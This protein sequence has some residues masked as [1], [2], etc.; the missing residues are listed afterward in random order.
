VYADVGDEQSIERDLSTFSAHIANV[1]AIVD[2]HIG[3]ALVLLDEP[4]VG[5]DPEEGAALG[6]GIIRTLDALGAR[7]VVT[8][9]YAAIKVFALS[10][11]SC[12]TAAVGYDLETMTPRYRLTYHSVGESLALPIARRLGLPERILDA[13]EAAR[14]EHARAL[15][16]AMERL[17]ETRRRYEERAAQAE[18]HVR[19]SREMEEETKRLLEELRQKRRRRW[20]EELEEARAFVRNLRER[21]GALLA[22]IER[23]AVDRRDL[24]RFLK[25]EDAGIVKQ[26]AS[27]EEPPTSDATPPTV[28]AAANC[29][30]WRVTAPGSAAAPCASRCRPRRCAASAK[31][32]R[33]RC[34]FACSH[35]RR[36]HLTRSASSVCAHAKPSKGWKPSS[37]T[38]RAPATRPCASFTALAAAP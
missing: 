10:Q 20:A 11:D 27:F 16:A 8:T 25:E 19:R 28:G 35:R 37:T 36:T 1:S 26:A 2:R 31:R 30:R 34:K 21:G 38:R 9:H 33:K 6:I 14:S 7:V 15:A 17:E 23:G 22:A 4:G 13:S 5:T 24:R 29:S 12:V 32:C 18:E 3:P